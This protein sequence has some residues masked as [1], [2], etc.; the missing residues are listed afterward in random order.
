MNDMVQ[1]VCEFIYACY[2][3]KIIQ[4][5][6]QSV[7]LHVATAIAQLAE[8]HVRNRKV[9]IFGSTGNDKNIK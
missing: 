3:W 2:F 7:S 4:F 5:L 8:S 9:A 1:E 6:H